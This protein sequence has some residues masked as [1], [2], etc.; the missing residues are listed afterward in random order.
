LVN[1]PI[2]NYCRVVSFKLSRKCLESC[3]RRRMLY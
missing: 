2:A 3:K 1:L